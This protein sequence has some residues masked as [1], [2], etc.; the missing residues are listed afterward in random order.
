MAANVATE[1]D[2]VAFSQA[3]AGETASGVSI[4]PTP[5]VVT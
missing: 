3:R 2:G 1:H 4:T 5:A